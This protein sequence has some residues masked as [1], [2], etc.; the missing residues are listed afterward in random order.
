MPLR[1]F[2]EAAKKKGTT[3]LEFKPE[4]GETLDQ[5]STTIFLLS[6]EL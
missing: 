2:R 6:I 1:E 3:P 4:E 5:V